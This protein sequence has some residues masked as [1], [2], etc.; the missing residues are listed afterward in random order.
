MSD[1]RTKLAFISSRA[2]CVRDK[3]IRPKMKYN[4]ISFLYA[5]LLNVDCVKFLCA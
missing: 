4:F 5:R 2:Q 1:E 3:Y